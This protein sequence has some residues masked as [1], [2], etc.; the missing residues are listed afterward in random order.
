MYNSSWFFARHPVFTVADFAAAAP[1]RGQRGTE[2]LLAYHLAAGHIIRIRRGLYAAIPEGIESDYIVDPYLVA[3]KCADDAVIAYHAAL[4]FHGFA[5]TVMQKITFF[6]REEDKKPFTFQG[7]HYLPVQHPRKLVRAKQESAATDKQDYRGMHIAV[8]SIE[9]TLVD[10]FDRV[11]VAGGIEEVWRSLDSVSYLRMDLL[12]NY[13]LLLD[14]AT[15]IAKVGF[16]LNK[17]K[18]RLSISDSKLQLLREHKP[19]KPQYMFRT[20]REGKL[21]ADW[22]L[23]VP[24]SVLERTWE[25]VM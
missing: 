10:C 24:E 1:E 23:I 4:A 8:T 13:A 6:T 17:H 20:K 21:V 25:E 16:Y 19:K 15:T 12:I 3:G 5:Y 22:N 7:C 14:N 18:D 9:R 11:D 2:N